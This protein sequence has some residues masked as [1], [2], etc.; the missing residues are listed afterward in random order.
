[1]IEKG[2]PVA[3]KQEQKLMSG[4]EPYLESGERVLGAVVAQARGRT[5]A[6]AGNSGIGGRQVGK[7]LDASEQAGL[8]IDNPMGVVITDRRLMTLKIG[9]PIGLGLGG[10]VKDFLS[11]VPLAEVEN[12]ETKRA[13]LAKLLLLTVHGSQIKLEANAAANTD[14][15][16][17]AFRTYRSSPS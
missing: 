7:V 15:I 6:I 1:V 3:S 4:A 11:A 9:A 16:A 2:T 14:S 17:A 13:G 8:K 12:V 5:Q 10:A